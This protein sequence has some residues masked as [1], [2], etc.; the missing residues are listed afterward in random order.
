MLLR[1]ARIYEEETGQQEEAI[2]TYRRASGADPDNREALVAL[3]R[4]YAR[5]QQWEELAHVVRSEIRIASSDED[6][7]GLTFRL[8]QIYELAL[9]DM[10]K[11]VEAYREVLTAEPAHAETRAAL[12]RMF[13]GGTM[14]LEI[15]DV[16]EPLYR[17]G[18]EWEK[19]HQ[20]Y[21]VQLGRLTDV[22]ERQT[23]LRRLAEI[24]E[25]KLVDQVAAFGWWAE[26]VKEDPSS[27]Q[28]L[29]ELLRLA[30]ATHQ[31]EAF[32]TTM[33]DAAAP[34]RA[35][36]VRR[37][38]LLR[39]AAS[40]ETDLG[41]LERAEKALLQVHSEH[42]K[43][44][45]ALASLDRIYDSQGMYENLAGILRQRI[46][47]TDDTAELVTLQLR[48]GRVYGEALDEVDPAIAS[49]L[50]VLEQQSR[51]PEALDALERLYFRSE[52]WRELYG[53]YEKWSTSPPTR[54][55]WR[56]ATRGW[57]RSPP[58]RSTIGPRPWSCGAAS[59]TCVARTP[60][61]C[62][63][64]PISTRWRASGRS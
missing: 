38:V 62:P 16:L 7:V 9:M 19:L 21:E 37:D 18:Q 40:F 51:S 46:A 43:D 35:P 57:R 4:L 10:S 47:T 2:A 1:L 52:R 3:D 39:L 60:S 29:D 54:W 41:D 30:R 61:R 23:L 44:A 42:E 55:A 13:L 12:E 56:T 64:S 8:A 45:V 14:Q 11:A 33:T 25:H 5:A 22:A 32:V 24:A 53:I 36:D 6:R 58:T 15:A 63:G 20:I 50:A 17:Q 28:A 27:A 26:A 48:L 49:Y 34:A 31:W 59:S